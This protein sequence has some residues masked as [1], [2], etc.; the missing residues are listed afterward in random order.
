LIHAGFHHVVELGFV[1]FYKFGVNL[2]FGFAMRVG[3]EFIFFVLGPILGKLFFCFQDGWEQ[4]V[5]LGDAVPD[6]IG[7]RL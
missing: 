7:G 6:A 5:G 1:G 2:F 3:A 4:G